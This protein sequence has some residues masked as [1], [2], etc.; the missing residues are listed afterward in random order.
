MYVNVHNNFTPISDGL[1]TD[2]CNLFVLY[3]RVIN[4]HSL[5]AFRAAFRIASADEPCAAR[6]VQ[7]ECGSA[8]QAATGQRAALRPH[9][10]FA[11]HDATRA[12]VR[13]TSLRP[14]AARRADAGAR[15]GL[16]EHCSSRTRPHAGRCVGDLRKG[17]AYSYLRQ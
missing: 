9:S 14:N 2:D 11:L 15:G 3:V 8:A 10:A 16:V 7:S 5:C 17:E 4:N 6:H 13:G 12:A 1:L